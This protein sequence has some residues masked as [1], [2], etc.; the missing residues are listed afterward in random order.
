MVRRTVMLVYFH[1]CLASNPSCQVLAVADGQHIGRDHIRT[2]VPIT[3]DNDSLV[4][5]S[6]RTGRQ[7]SRTVGRVVRFGKSH[8]SWS[9]P[10][11]VHEPLYTSSWLRA[12]SQVFGC[13]AR[14]LDPVVCPSVAKLQR[15]P[16]CTQAKNIS[17][18]R[19]CRKP[20]LA[21]QTCETDCPRKRALHICTGKTWTASQR[22]PERENNLCHKFL[23]VHPTHITTTTQAITFQD[24]SQH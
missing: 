10:G 2:D 7:R 21:Q 3:A 13:A 19:L 18:A 24:A 23:T 4:R 22:S 14:R 16:V 5:S 11:R 8:E 17:S 20:C 9:G 1:L 12:D 6:L 15:Y